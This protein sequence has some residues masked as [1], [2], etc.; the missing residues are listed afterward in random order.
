M[1]NYPIYPIHSMKLIHLSLLSWSSTVRFKLT[2]ELSIRSQPS[3][4]CCTRF[5]G[6]LRYRIRCSCRN[7]SNLLSY[8]VISKTFQKKST[9]HI[10]VVFVRCGFCVRKERSL[11]F[12]DFSSHLSFL[13]SFCVW[14]LI[15]SIF[16]CR[17]WRNSTR[18]VAFSALWKSHG[19]WLVAVST[20]NFSVAID[21]NKVHFMEKKASPTNVA[22]KLTCEVFKRSCF[23]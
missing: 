22:T 3:G 20:S 18:G 15:R 23:W 19:R 16:P 12:F 14:L 17:L 2:N 21:M 5:A 7:S 9:F 11:D 10:V 1:C 13:W 6:P 8:F 4:L